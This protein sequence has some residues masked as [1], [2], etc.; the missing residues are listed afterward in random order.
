M[1]DLAT[2]EQAQKHQQFNKLLLAGLQ[3]GQGRN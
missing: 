1:A 2:P 3:A